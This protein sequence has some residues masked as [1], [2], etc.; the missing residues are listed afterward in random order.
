MHTE[1]DPQAEPQPTPPPDATPVVR[2]LVRLRAA[3]R[4][5]LIFQSSGVLLAFA[6]VAIILVA[7]LDFVVRMPTGVRVILW[8]IGACT[9]AIAAYRRVTPALKF[10]PPLAEIAIR[11]ENTP[12]GRRAGLRGV[13]AAGLELAEQGSNIPTTAHLSQHAVARA[14]EQLAIVRPRALLLRPANTRRVAGLLLASLTVAA[15]LWVWKHDLAHIGARRVLTPWAD[16]SWPKRTGLIDAHPLEAHPTTAAL[17]LRALLTKTPYAQGKTDVAVSYHV[18]INGKKGPS[19]R[20]LLTSQGPR[21]LEGPTPLS[22]ELF[23]RLLEPA[24]LL[25]AGE[26]PREHATAVLEYSFETDDDATASHRV[27]LVEP[28]AIRAAT[29]VITPPAYALNVLGNESPFAVG[30]RDVGPGT[31]PRATIS[32]VLRGSRVR[33]ELELNKP[34]AIQGGEPR[35]IL[36]AMAPGAN[37]PADAKVDVSS[38]TWKI[39]WRADASVRVPIV[40]RDQYGLGSVDEPVYRVEVA[41]D[42]V[43]TALVIE[44]AQDESVL[45]T[46]LV[47]SSVEGRDDVALR[48]ISLQTQK[49]VQEPTSAGAPPE[50]KGEPVPLALKDTWATGEDR[51]KARVAASIDLASM[52]LRS[53]DEVWITGVATDAYDLD[54][55]TH[56]PTRSAI[57]RL[58]IISESEFVEQVRAELA[59][60]REASMRLEQ[61]QAR[62]SES[63]PQALDHREAA[64]QQRDRQRSIG[65]RLG[66]LDD[67]LKRLAQRMERNQFADREMR[68]LLDDATGLLQSA[69]ESS[70]EAQQSLDELTKPDRGRQERER[71]AAR[72]G[73]QQKATDDSLTQLANMLDRG[74]DSWAVRRQ[75]EK[76]LSDQRQVQAQTKATGQS[77]RGQDASALHPQE[78]L[79]LEQLAQRQQE[80][81]QRGSQAIDQLQQRAQQMEKADQGQS[82]A[83]KQAAKEARETQLEA[84]QRDAAE[85]I[86]KNQT[87][88]AEQQQ[89]QAISSIRKM[90]QQ[91][92]D[93]QQQRDQALRRQIAELAD[94]LRKLVQR[95]DQEIALLGKGM[96]GAGLDGLDRGMIAINTD[97]LAAEERV[98]K[99]L[100]GAGK[101]V[102]LL[103]S[104]ADAQSSAISA[105]RLKP[106]D[107]PQADES[108]RTSLSRLREA[109]VELE[110]LEDDAQEAERQQ[111]RGELLRAYQEALEKQVAIAGEAR[112]FVGK[113][114]GRRERVTL[115]TIGDKQQTLHAEVAKVRSENQDIG[116]SELFD[117]AHRRLD[118]VQSAAAKALLEGEATTQVKQDQDSAVAVLRSL[119]EALKDAQKKKDDFREN[120]GGGGGGGQGG[121]GGQKPKLL[122]PYSE[123]KLLRM[124]QQEA[125]ERTRSA[126]DA[127][128][129]VEPV[130][131]LQRE[132]ADLAQKL[133]EKVKS[134]G[135]GGMPVS[136]TREPEVHPEGGATPSPADEA[137]KGEG[138]APPPAEKAEEQAKQGGRR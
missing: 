66:P 114:I 80:L 120:E 74:Q 67:V 18:E 101:I 96:A 97:T 127:G 20:V 19:Q 100:R 60:V 34:L 121:Q 83:M 28:P 105:L 79:E 14:V 53:G 45:P 37:L 1:G 51:T 91:L 84:T 130:G 116:D 64:A 17:P 118:R 128:E 9:L 44:P 23:E 123:L 24:A 57:R 122:P 113:E 48:S 94:Q 88:Q 112:A 135:R 12:E 136:P 10:R 49:A 82:Q 29:L 133:L 110:K 131:D 58:R 33:L 86:R 75:L 77:L 61:E 124:M 132:L 111:K 134:A 107:G 85:Q 78:R 13:I 89:E 87:S 72:A 39:E 16:V 81:A 15:G 76:L 99:E 63:R 138:A 129:V 11:L 2:T 22:G 95:Q 117:F 65:D 90:L 106:A 5:R 46:A 126:S 108:E 98:R 102:G 26:G 52:A 25:G 93:V 43:P 38:A 31:D 32:P 56:E 6:I 30:A 115:R 35:A 59:A 73:E 69:A 125:A 68:G 7:F 92:D 54:G 62:L 47:P 70:R 109:L 104:A 103:G 50:S 71:A 4:R 36:G 41:D 55:L 21:T 40:L 119:V 27:A 8:L 3:A 42:R 137:V